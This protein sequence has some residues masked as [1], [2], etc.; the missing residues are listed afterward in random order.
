MT[1]YIVNFDSAKLPGL[2]TDFL[3]I[4]SGNAGLRASIEASQHGEV[5]IITKDAMK[6]SSTRYA[7]GG[8]AVAMSEED[9]VAAHVADTLNAGVG[10]CDEE[11]VKVMV[12]EGIPRVRELIAWGANFDKDN[13]RIGFTREGAHGRRRIIHARGDAT[14]EETED[15]LVTRGSKIENVRII[16]HAFAIDLLTANNT[17]YGAL[18]LQNGTLMC[19][20]AKAVIVAAG[21][22]G[23]IYK[24]TSNPEVTTGDGC[25]T[26]YRAGCEMMDMEFVQFHPTTLYLAGAPRFLISESVRGEGGLL[27]NTNGERFMP[28]YHEMAE[29]APRDI[30]SRTI[31]KEMQQTASDCVYLDITHLNPNFIRNRFPTISRTCASY[32]LDITKELI[33][34]QP[35]AHYMMG[36]VRTDTQATTNLRGLYACGEVACTGVHGANRL[37]SNSLLEGLVFGTRAGRYAAIYASNIEAPPEIRIKFDEVPLDDI[38]A[39]IDALKAEVQNLMWERAGVLR[40]GA[41]LADALWILEHLRHPTAGHNRK[42]LE[43][44]NMIQVAQLIIRAALK[45]TESRGA[46]YRTDYPARDDENWKRHLILRRYSGSTPIS[47]APLPV[48]NWEESQLP[49]SFY[50]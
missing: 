19:I 22:L 14:G 29:L 50:A 3:V 46:H 24:Y 16:E 11:V 20:W 2:K 40:D 13:G 30:V 4:G 17:C 26:A 12:E 28:A 8:I 35:A 43:L 27:R 44:Q 42:A 23:Q 45:R 18:V 37:A 33:P 34:V 7:Q 47:E 36:G 32:G 21:G 9:T 48:G 1:R 38:E 39:D 10:L 6:E 41:N 49:I 31:D 25:A 15:T 5:I